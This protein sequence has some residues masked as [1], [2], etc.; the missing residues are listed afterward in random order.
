[1]RLLALTLLGVVIAAES[2][3][4]AGVQFETTHKDLGKVKSAAEVQQAFPF[5]VTGSEPVEFVE[6]RP[7]CGC[8]VPQMQK[9]VYQ[10]GEK[11]QVMVG[12]HTITQAP[13]KHRFQVSLTVRDPEERTIVL[14]ADIE[15]E[16][17]ISVQPSN[18]RFVVNGQRALQQTVSVVDPRPKKLT[19]KEVVSSSP[20]IEASP[21]RTAEG[22]RAVQLTVSSEIPQGTHEERLVLRTDDPAYAEM[23]LPITLVHPP[24]VQAV[25][26]NLRL[27]ALAHGETLRR[28]LLIRD[29]RGAAVS[30]KQVD[31][32]PGIDCKTV[33]GQGYV[34]LDLS[35]QPNRLPQ[36]SNI[37]VHVDKPTPATIDI[38]VT[39]Q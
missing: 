2:Q 5:I 31:C 14:A 26:G 9:R 18:L 20:Y 10:P 32:P 21:M 11:G 17:E 6:L 39:T 7:S 29:I 25:P 30:L 27:P 3:A 38:P 8:V 24:R 1:M 13:G 12:L 36:Q 4:I 33:P 37:Q 22:T 23:V 19:V 35:I 28:S 34:R 16:R 15:L